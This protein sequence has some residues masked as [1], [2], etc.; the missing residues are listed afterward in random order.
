VE[1]VERPRGGIPAGLWW[2]ILIVVLGLFGGACLF[3]FSDNWENQNVQA[4]SDAVNRGDDFLADANY[5]NAA[6]EYRYVV[7]LIGHRKIQSVYIQQL[8]DHARYGIANAEGRQRAILATTTVSPVTQLSPATEPAYAVEEAL[9]GFQRNEEAFP[10]FVRSRPIVFRDRDGGWRKRRYVVWDEHYDP[11]AMKEPL[12]LA[13]RYSVG[14][15]IT[16]PHFSRVDA[17]TDDN[18]RHDEAPLVV[19]CETAFMWTPSQWVIERR[20][21]NADKEGQSSDDVRPSLDDFFPMER[22]VF[23]VSG[24]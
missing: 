19:K 1:D 5:V 10:G 22:Q 15:Q 12:R 7:D 13:L 9:K 16:D 21:V 4:L 17:G 14:S 8:L 23:G 11:P 24:K 18:F 20:D 6:T 2:A 3:L